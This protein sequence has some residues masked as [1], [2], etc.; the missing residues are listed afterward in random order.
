MRIILIGYR[1]YT[2]RTER[3]TAPD[4]LGDTGGDHDLY[5]YCADDPVNAED[6]WGLESNAL[7]TSIS[8]ISDKISSWW[9]RIHKAKIV[10]TVD[11]V[12][13]PVG[14]AM[15]LMKTDDA[16]RNAIED[17]EQTQRKWKDGIKDNDADKIIKAYSESWNNTVKNIRSIFD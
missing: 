1:D 6:P 14:D 2:P 11:D 10:K 5:E 8:K 9:D 15:D 3:F 7:M 16:L 12:A 13:G 4:P 17:R